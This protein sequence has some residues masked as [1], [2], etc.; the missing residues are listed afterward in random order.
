MLKGRAIKA[1]IIE[2]GLTVSQTAEELGIS[3]QT[4]NNKINGHSEWT[5]TEYNK[6]CE[7]LKAPEEAIQ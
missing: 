6:L 5:V 7:I 4:L 3:R 1:K 2:C